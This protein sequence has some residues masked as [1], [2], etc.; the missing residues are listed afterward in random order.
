MLYPHDKASHHVQL[1]REG[2]FKFIA[3]IF[4]HPIF[5][6]CWAL[7]LWGS[8]YHRH[9]HRGLCGVTWCEG[10]VL[11]VMISIQP[12]RIPIAL[13]MVRVA[14]GRVTVRSCCWGTYHSIAV[15]CKA[16]EFTHG[17]SNSDTSAK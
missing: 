13:D 12:K 6:P 1:P 9:V 16:G 5:G 14:W 11:P 8:A 10:G 4:Q 7:S 17:V 15:K 3:N 2:K